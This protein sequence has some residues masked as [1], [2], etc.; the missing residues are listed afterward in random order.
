MIV[1]GLGNPGTEYA[2]TRHNAGYKV[3]DALSF[4]SGIRL[5]KKFLRPAYIGKG[6][7]R[8]K[9]LFLVKPL[10]YMNR[11]GDVIPWILESC[12][13]NPAEIVVI[14]DH[15]DLEPGR[16]RL[17][18]SGSSGGQ[19]GLESIISVLSTNEF[20]RMMVGIGRPADGTK[21]HDYVLGVPDDGSTAVLEAAYL[22][23][24]EHILRL[25]DEPIDR[26]MNDVNRRNIE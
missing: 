14:A 23:A 8:G 12:H 24:A 6:F 22:R 17:R 2:E 4:Y 5:K 20:P 19:K 1:I 18:S 21:I 7:Y 10:T 13:A 15:L 9:S 25:V 3:I 26:V 11:S 16:L